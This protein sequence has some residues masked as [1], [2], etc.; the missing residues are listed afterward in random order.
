MPDRRSRRR[1]LRW[2]VAV[3]IIA[4]IV[5]VAA[6]L[7]WVAVNFYRIVKLMG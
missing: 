2:I 6:G 7:A 1:V 3:A 4:A 5:A